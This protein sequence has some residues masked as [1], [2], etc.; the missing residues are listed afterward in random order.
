VPRRRRQRP[1]HPLHPRYWPTWLGAGVLGALSSLPLTWQ[2]RLGEFVGR[3][4][5]RAL[6]RRRRIARIN[7]ELCFPHLEATERGRLL[8]RHFEAAGIGLFETAIAWFRN[9]ARLRHRL[10]LEGRTHLEAALAAPE[11]TLLVGAHFVTLEIVGALLAQ[12]TDFDTVYRPHGNPVLERL[13]RRARTRHYGELIDRSDLRG[14]VRRLRAGRTV[15]YAPDQDPGA[16]RAVFVPFFG[17]PA[18]ALTAGARLARLTG[19]QVLLIDHWRD[20]A[21]MTWTVRFRPAPKGIPSDNA[22]ADTRRLTLALEEAVAA[23]PEQYLWLHRRF[24][25]HPSGAMPRY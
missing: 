4:G 17:V 9:P 2:R 25:T 12:T 24:K 5:Q 19:A 18:A 11:G 14:I 13:Q 23:H 8:E 1:A 22:G 6:G 20:A 10:H 3:L 15:W 7:L 21:T 16:G